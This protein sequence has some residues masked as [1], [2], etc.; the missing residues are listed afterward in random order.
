MVRLRQGRSGGGGGG[1]GGLTLM[2]SRSRCEDCGNKAKK[3]CLYMRCRTCC[4]NNG[5]E[6]QTHIKSTWVPLH[7][8][9]L[10]HDERHTDDDHH[11]QQRLA[12]DQEHIIINPNK[13]LRQHNPSS[14]S[15]G[16]CYSCVQ[17]NSHFSVLGVSL[18]VLELISTHNS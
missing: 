8:R 4:K 16:T 7:K 3:G 5:F 13:R 2:G 14:Q 18:R 1:G 10:L 11:Q 17:I 12:I 9:S 15:A 6:C